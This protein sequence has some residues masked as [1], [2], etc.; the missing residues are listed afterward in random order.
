MLFIL[1]A[2]AHHLLGFVHGSGSRSWR[3]CMIHV[4][5][6]TIKIMLVVQ[7]LL[8]NGVVARS[9]GEDSFLVIWQLVGV[10][11]VFLSH[12]VGVLKLWHSE[13]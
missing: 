11:Q 2:S 1:V 10:L 12:V 6:V 7:R 13:L 3:E 4:V 8:F 5:V 9:L